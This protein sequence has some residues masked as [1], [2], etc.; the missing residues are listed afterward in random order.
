MKLYVEDEL[1]RKS[2][3]EMYQIAVEE[4]LLES[5]FTNPTREELINIIMKYRGK[6][7]SNV[8]EHYRKNGL[9][10]LQYLFDEKLHERLHT[11]NRIKIP[12]KIILYKELNLT[13]EDNYK[14]VIPE[15]IHD[16][17]VFLMNGNNYL[18]GIFHLEK[19]LTTKYTYYLTSRKEFLRV[20]NL[21]N[22]KFSLIFF[23]SV[24]SRFLFN[25]YNIT[26]EQQYE[27]YPY[28]LDYYKVDI[29]SFEVR[30]L[31][32]TETTL[33]IDFGT[34]NTAIG[35]YLDQYYIDALPSNDI[36]NG[37]I[38]LN[39]INYARFYNGEG[40]YNEI[41]PTS[42][43]VED[44]SDI[45][46]IKYLFGY[47]VEKKLEANDYVVNGSL[48][49]GIKKWV[50]DYDKD[51]RI[52]DELGNIRIVKKKDII[53]AYLDYVVK[54]AE[55]L[56]KCKFKRIHTSSPV[57]LKNQYLNMFQEIFTVYDSEKNVKRR[58]YE[59]IRENA[60]DEAIAVLYNTIEKV[61]KKEKYIDDQE[62]RAL[63]IDCGGGT[64]ELAACKYKIR[65]GELAYELDLSTSFENGNENFG[66]NNLTYRIM[67]FLKVILASRYTKKADEKLKTVNE[68]IDLETAYIYKMVDECGIDE[69]FKNLNEEY[70]LAEKIIPT[71]YAKYENK[72]STIYR[73]VKNNFFMLWEAAE[74]L[75]TYFFNGDDTLRTR[76]DLG[77]NFKKE[78]DFH[79]TPL[80]SWR[81][82]ISKDGNFEEINDFPDIIFTIREIEKI[83][84]VDIYT[85]L[86]K[87][88]D[89]Y[90]KEGELLKY[91]LIKL[92]GQS[93]KIDTFQ[94]VLKE[95]IPGKMMEFKELNSNNYELKLNCLDGVIKYFNYRRF[96]HMKV[97]IKNEIPKVPY[98]VWAERYD[99]KKELMIKTAE[100]EGERI[101]LGLIDKL[102][103]AGDL[104]LYVYD[105]EN[106]LK[107]EVLFKH[108]LDDLIE[109]DAKDIIKDEF[110][111]QIEQ[112][113]IDESKVGT[114]RFFI[115]TD[116]NSWGFHVLPVHRKEERQVYCGK[117][118]YF[119]FEDK[120]DEISFF[121]G[122]H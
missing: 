7:E 25:F 120:I 113:L 99:G 79:I 17:N 22:N 23:K 44:C 114:I 61:I 41:F 10:Y 37:S 16:G 112:R 90:Y 83:V 4:K 116:E 58:E 46:N 43:Y 110:D 53:K 47:D 70:E 65:R 27:L 100:N 35:A 74:R 60:M 30:N 12:H 18:C 72:M 19:D 86:K 93:V 107:K 69:I 122:E 1:R 40:K 98:S 119:P 97:K 102:I 56:F 118:G 28:K 67:Q 54:R 101:Q 11:E 31:E 64:T 6:K 94:E 121:D 85:M 105:S 81:L 115:F 59:I 68:I 24:D 89:T 87:F 109:K 75:K 88:L 104:K 108:N 13:K 106:Q 51:E 84:K 39:E 62:Y 95:F 80:K 117:R 20:D 111:N 36:L 78:N 42:V 82:Y 15:Y 103:T 73:Y 21:T 77:R 57:K 2:Y 8:I 38:K 3:Y 34:C 33:C 55:Y 92:S 52:V 50:H 71:K 26:D 14:I 91:S 29:E 63:I 5:Y 76:F 9:A 96:G 49:Y 32:T 45:N 48:F 66:G